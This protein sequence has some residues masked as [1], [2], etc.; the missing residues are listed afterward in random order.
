M[1]N[2]RRLTLECRRQHRFCVPR[3][4]FRDLGLCD[5]GFW[6]GLRGNGLLGDR[7]RGLRLGLLDGL[8][9]G[10]RLF[11]DRFLRGWSERELPLPERLLRRFL[12]LDRMLRRGGTSRF[13]RVPLPRSALRADG[14]LRLRLRGRLSI[15]LALPKRLLRVGVRLRLRRGL[16]RRGLPLRL[17]VE[18]DLLLPDRLVAHDLAPGDA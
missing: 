4:R 2:D 14:P 17:A 3:L 5:N 8:D 10:N 16:L 11:D 9:L 7:R 15:D 12:R 18:G 6:L 1:N 13:P